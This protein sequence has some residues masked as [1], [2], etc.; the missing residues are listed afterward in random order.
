MYIGQIGC[1]QVKEIKYRC[2]LLSLLKLVGVSV[3]DIYLP[4]FSC[5]PYYNGTSEL[6]V[7]NNNI[8]LAYKQEQGNCMISQELVIFG[9]SFSD[10]MTQQHVLPC[11]LYFTILR[12]GNPPRSYFLDVDTGSD[13]TWMQCDAPCTS[14]GKVYFVINQISIHLRQMCEIFIQHLLPFFMYVPVSK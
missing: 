6:F 5:G 1:F 9:N 8:Q 7:C 3:F 11:R 14:C 13:L 10:V 2:M 4:F 12:V